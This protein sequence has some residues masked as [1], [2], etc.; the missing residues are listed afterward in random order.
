MSLNCNEINVIL[1]ELSLEGSFI[2]DIVQPGFN[3]LA[4]YT[5]KN[6]SRKT[7][8]IC[9]AHDV[10]RI[11][12]TKQK[13]TRNDKPLRFMELLKSKIKGARIDSCIQIG[14]D[15]IVAMK[16]SHGEETLWLYV[17]LW[18]AAANVVL[19]DEDNVIIDAMF[20]RPAK[21]ETTGKKFLLSVKDTGK[22]QKEW[23]VRTFDEVQAEYD[24]LHADNTILSFNE[25][26][27]AWYS[28]H[29]HALSVDVLRAQTEKWYSTTKIKREAALEKL[30]AKQAVFKNAKQYKHQGDLVLSYGHVI[31]GTSNFIECEDYTT[32]NTVRIAINPQKTAQ[33]NAALYYEQYK[34]AQHGLAQLEHDIALE[35]KQIESLNALFLQDFVHE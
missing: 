32:G 29:A 18:S 22:M 6:A 14:L 27:D 12:S 3:T 35:E 5:Y 9:T 2:Q 15:R 28:N 34:K 33:E 30:K 1:S 8:L 23:P 17:R 10:C 20:R 25:K 4:L 31:D 13:I 26:V 24:A 7:I 11:H 21:N 19:C 16:L